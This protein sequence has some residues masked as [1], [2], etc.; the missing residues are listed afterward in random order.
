[1]FHIGGRFRR[2][3]FTIGMAGTAHLSKDGGLARPCRGRVVAV[4]CS[5]FF[6]DVGEGGSSWTAAMPSQAVGGNEAHVMVQKNM[7]TMT[8]AR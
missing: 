8:Y 5:A 2:S 1:M 4:S 6:F 7:T 3:L